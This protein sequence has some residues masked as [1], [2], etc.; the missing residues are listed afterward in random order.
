MTHVVHLFDESAGWEQRVAVTQLLDR[1]S[2]DDFN[3]TLATL[4][5]AGGSALR[6]LDV[7]IHAFPLLAGVDAL[8]SPLVERF[9]SRRNVDLIHAWGPRAATV[10]AA[11]GR[12]TVVELFDP[13]HATRHIKRLRAIARTIGFAVICTS[14]WARR[15]L[16]EGGLPPNLCVVVRPAIDF[17][18]VNA[19]RRTTLRE[20]LGV[21]AGDFVAITPEPA[22]RNGGHLQAYGAAALLRSANHNIRLIISGHS[23]EQRRIARLDRTTPKPRTLV[24]PGYAYPFEQLLP[25][26]DALIVPS[27]GDTS[28]TAIAW[29]MASNVAVIGTAVHSVAELIANK[30]NGLLFKQTPG[31]DMAPAIAKL[32][33]DRESQEKTKEVARGQAYEVFGLRRCI[34]QH[35]KVYEN[36]LSGVAP[37]E[38]I[39]DSAQP[40]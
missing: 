24:S 20:A 34:E 36:V 16:I 7:A 39:I 2:R 12:P 17:A 3:Q 1:L 14:Q 32:L 37:G 11:A 30:L 4:H 5:P 26:A 15:R 28:T 31:K 38:G 8:V 40:N 13:L 21:S 27:R 19:S 23:R 6:S 10:A 18:L 35:V 29:A 33:L 25:A 9:A 22:T